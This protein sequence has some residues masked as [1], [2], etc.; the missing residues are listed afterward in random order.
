[1]Q[2]SAL[3]FQVITPP[4]IWEPRSV[5][6][7]RVVLA[8]E[9]AD[10]VSLMALATG[11]ERALQSSAFQGDLPGIKKRELGI[12]APGKDREPEGQGQAGDGVAQQLGQPP[13]R[14]AGG[15]GV[16]FAL[17]LGLIESQGGLGLEHRQ[18]QGE[19]RRRH[20]G[21]AEGLEADI[22]I[23]AAGGLAGRL[24]GWPAGAPPAPG[25]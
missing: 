4:G 15:K 13:Q 24:A 5:P 16:A 8:A 6:G 17:D 25:G 2:G 3:R 1:M 12:P 11:S 18:G 19:I 9:L 7:G 23:G 22:E 14:I 20:P 10:V 21:A